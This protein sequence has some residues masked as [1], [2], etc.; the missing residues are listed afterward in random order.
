MCRTDLADVTQ[1]AHLERWL[2]CD[3]WAAGDKKDFKKSQHFKYKTKNWLHISNSRADLSI[4]YSC[5]TNVSFL[6]EKM[7]IWGQNYPFLLL[8]SHLQTGI[9]CK[10][11]WF[12][13]TFL[14][15]ICDKSCQENCD[16]FF[17]FLKSAITMLRKR[18]AS[19][20]RPVLQGEA[21]VWVLSV[22]RGAGLAGNRQAPF[23]VL[24]GLNLSDR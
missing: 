13:L 8:P 3:V 21:G 2:R 22:Q 5:L 20:L 9:I 14:L 19:S 17:N 7:Q 16:D 4:K 11:N 23:D 12:I 15:L 1:R 6:L 24:G 18:L 10:E